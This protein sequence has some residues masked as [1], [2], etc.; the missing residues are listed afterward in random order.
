MTLRELITKIGFKVD[1]RGANEAE[2]RVK[3]MSLGM[4]TAITGIVAGIGLLGAAA[5]DA[6]GDMEMLTTQFEVMLG[7]S[8][9]AVALMEELKAF[10]AATPFALEDLAT[11]T[12]QLLSFGVAQEDVIKTMQMLGDTAGG[13]AE[14]LSGLVLAYGKVTTKGKASLEEINMMAERGLPIF[15]ILSEEMGVSREQLFKLISAGKVSAENITNAFRT[16]TSEGGMFFEGMKKQSLTFQGLVSTLKDNVKLMVASIGETLLPIAKQIIVTLTELVQ[17]PIGELVGALVGSL[18][19]ILEIVASLIGDVV[20]AML[21]LASILES[22]MPLV[23][24]LL[25]VLDH[26]GP[27]LGII[28]FLFTELGKIIA[29]LVPPLNDLLAILVEVFAILWNIAGSAIMSLLDPLLTIITDLALILADVLKVLNPILRVVLQLLAFGIGAAL[30]LILV[31]IWLLSKAISIIIGLIRLVVNV[32]SKVLYPIFKTYEII[33]LVLVHLI[34]T[35]FNFIKNGVQSGIQSFKEFLGFIGDRFLNTVKSKFSSFKEWITELISGII[36]W[37]VNI[38]NKFWDWFSSKFPE[39]AKRV[40]RFAQVFI[41][42]WRFFR[43]SFKTV[44][45]W[46]MSMIQKLFDW[47]NKIPGINI[48]FG[49]GGEDPEAGGTALAQGLQDAVVAANP[50]ANP[51]I[52]NAGRTA[53]VS[54]QNEIRVTV[55]QGANTEAI[56]TSV[57]EAAR[58]VFTVELKRIL[59]D[60]GY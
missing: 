29:I 49:G 6:A 20:N 48:D 13:N 53:N 55:P 42:I 28:T 47:L 8:E 27:L 17:G 45:D 44:W 41:N 3:K 9:K 50:E 25:S 12:Q 56:K 11:G 30:K 15:K 21:P 36:T 54:M 1:E 5:L 33:F 22:L 43:D 34:K 58:S 7:S 23:V 26:A 10:A 14:K 51:A 40:Q 24:T 18:G 35:F 37:V 2:D 4:K 39:A 32:L 16:M 46:V 38:L 31:P 60:A 19:P 59:V 52:T 57:E